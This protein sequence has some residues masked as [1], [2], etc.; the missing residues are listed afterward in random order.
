MAAVEEA[1]EH[2]DAHPALAALGNA[3]KLEGEPELLRV[4]EVV[5]LDV[6][7]PLVRNVLE[8]HRSTERQPREDRHLR[9]RVGAADVVGRVGLR[10]AQLLGTG[11]DVGEARPGLGHLGEDEVG[12]PVHDP[13]DLRDLGRAEALLDHPDHRN[14]PG[15]RRLEPKL[16]ACLTGRVEELVAVLR[17]ELLVRR[18]HVLAGLERPQHVVARRV[19]APDQ[20]D[21]D[22]GPGQDLVEVPLGSAQDPADLGAAPGDLR[23]RVGPL[24]HEVRER[25]PDRAPAQ[26]ADSRRLRH[27]GS[28]GPPRSRGAPRRGHRRP[29]RRSPADGPCRCSCSPSNGRRPR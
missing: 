25:A 23:H 10:V 16:D 6:R 17:H 22:V 28:P 19:G 20:L 5:G 11:E 13:E 15:H 27:R 14:R 8:A 21:D 2:P 12:R 24:G 3:E 7:D 4:G 26:E 1:G 9:R 18:D 29:C